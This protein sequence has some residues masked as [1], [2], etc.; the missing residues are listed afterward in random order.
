MNIFEIL[1]VQPLFNLLLLLYS[2]IPGGDFGVS[3][4]IFTILLR[5]AMYPLVKKQL[6]QTKLMRKMQ[7][8]LER[9]KKSTKGNRQAQSIQM[10]ELYKRH[11]VSPFRSIGV[12]LV[13]LPI[14]IALYIVISIFAMYRDELSR[15]TYDF[16]ENIPA[17]KHI[18]EN[19]HAFNEKLFGI[20]DLTK[21]AFAN[22]AISI[23]LIVIAVVAAIGQFIMSKQTMPTPSKRRSL[24]EIMRDAAEGKQADQSDINNAVMG[25]MIYMLPVFMLFIMVSLPGAIAVY[26]AVNTL[27]AIIQQHHI[28]KEDEEEL[29]EIADHPKQAGKKATAKARARAANEGT[30]TRIVAKGSVSSKPKRDKGGK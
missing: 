3:I 24:R 12:M 17:I 22:G 18:V 16:L 28:L 8:E 26:Y 1:I 6:H 10:M 5:F 27:V 9:I 23:P 15:W 29:E 30:V 21:H 14:F 19:P 13:Q 4:I 25:K 7:P 2:V 20:V 11:G